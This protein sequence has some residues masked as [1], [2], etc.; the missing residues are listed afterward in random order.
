[1]SIASTSRTPNT[2]VRLPAVKGRTGLSTSAIYR[3]MA[4]GT[5]PQSVTIGPNARAW[6]LSEI[7]EW[8]AARVAARD[9]GADR[10][11]RALNPSLGIGRR[12]AAQ[13]AA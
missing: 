7:E 5:F 3:D 11:T 9:A 12:A 4:A 1:M 13:H 2:L 6:L 8:I 10:A